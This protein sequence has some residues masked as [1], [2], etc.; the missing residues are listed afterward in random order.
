MSS[1]ARSRM[2]SIDTPDGPLSVCR[3][4][5]GERV[6]VAAHGIT[7][8]HAGFAALADVV[9][10][11]VTLLAPDLRGRGGSRDIAGP[12]GMRAHADDVVRILDALELP[13]ATL[14]GHSM[15]GFVAVVTTHLHPDRVLGIVLVDGGLPLE[16]PALD[17][18]P[19]EVVVQ[20]IIGPS[21]A[22]LRMTFPSLDAYLSFWRSHPALVD[23]WST[24]VE[25]Y[26]AADLAGD[27]PHLRSTVREDAVMADAASELR[28]PII[29]RALQSLTCSVTLLRAP[30]GVMNGEALY[31]EAVI[32]KWHSVVPQMTVRTVDNVNHFS[33]TLSGRGARAVA[34]ALDELWDRRPSCP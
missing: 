16:L 14:V 25:A 33:I 34:T 22:R 28:D 30:R 5:S 8:N 24:Y 20:A 1:A 32:E 2:L 15:G 12:F 13:A 6:V 21:L 7:A 31:P 26:L 3:W 18:Q 17:D 4:G 19:I 29:E 10:D 23:D 9:G 27:P 11:D